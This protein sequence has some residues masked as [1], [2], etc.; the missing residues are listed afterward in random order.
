MSRY[1]RLMLRE[2]EMTLKAL[3]E[4]YSLRSFKVAHCIRV[5]FEGLNV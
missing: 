5:M 3:L 2:S 4:S 1:A